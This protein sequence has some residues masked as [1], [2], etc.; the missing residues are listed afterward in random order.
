[1]SV[2]SNLGS[3]PEPEDLDYVE[4]EGDFMCATSN[5]KGSSEKAMYF[6]DKQILAWKCEFGHKSVSKDIKL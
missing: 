4:F 6:M 2:Y 5:C 1:M 3:T